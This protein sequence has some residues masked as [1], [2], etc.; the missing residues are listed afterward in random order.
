MTVTITAEQRDAL[1]DVILDRIAA[2]EDVWIAV[3]ADNFEHARRLGLAYSDVL[4]LVVED[5]GWGDTA[6]PDSIELKTPP[7]VL[8][9][10]FER[11]RSQALGMS[12]SEEKER[13]ELRES[14]RQNQMVLD[15]CEQ[16]L[17]GLDATHS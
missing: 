16:V 15:T 1:Y 5:L 9:R 10:V 6:P 14:Q 13:A 11:M 7:D 8:R 2:I 12:A 3:C 4:R 17:A